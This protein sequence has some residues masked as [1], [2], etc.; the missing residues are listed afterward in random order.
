MQSKLSFSVL[1]SLSKIRE[2]YWRSQ[3][4]QLGCDFKFIKSAEKRIGKKG[5]FLV[6][7]DWEMQVILENVGDELELIDMLQ[8]QITDYAIN[9]DGVTPLKQSSFSN[10]IS[11][12]SAISGSIN[13][14]SSGTNLT[15]SGK[16]GSAINPPADFASYFHQNVLKCD[17]SAAIK[18][19]QLH[20]LT[21]Y[22]RYKEAWLIL[23]KVANK[24][25][26]CLLSIGLQKWISSVK[27]DNNEKMLRDRKRWR[28]HTASNQEND[29]QAWYHSIFH[30]EVYRLRGPFWFRDAVLPVYRK[31]YAIV[32]TGMTSLE[33]AAVAHVLCSPDTTYGDVAGHMFVVQAIS[34]DNEYTLFQSLVSQGFPVIKYPRMGRPAKKHFRISF[35][36]GSVYFTWKGKFGNQ[37]I[38][39]GEVNSLTEGL[40]TDVL[41][42]TGSSSKGDLYVSL[43]SSGRS[44]DLCLENSGDKALWKLLLEKLV[45]KEHGLLPDIASEYPPQP[46][47]HPNPDVDLSWFVLYSAIGESVLSPSLKAHLLKVNIT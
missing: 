19:E 37:G 12:V 10:S 22:F 5:F 14:N 46:N 2:I 20:Q 6:F 34:T 18:Q 39:L 33:E 28:L 15:A 40:S 1:T 38:N 47:G 16:G 9:G 7:L 32:D 26:N 30:E 43:V 31:S 24:S 36:E 44:V 45:A 21:R 17:Y 41:K 23:D 11:S 13:I 42:R 3:P 35:V 8:K 25:R 4:T 27:V 29:L